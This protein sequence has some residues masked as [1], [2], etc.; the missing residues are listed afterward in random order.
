MLMNMGKYKVGGITTAAGIT[1]VGQKA[2]VTIRE[3][4]GAFL[5][6]KYYNPGANKG[7][8]IP[9]FRGILKLLNVFKMAFGTTI[10]KISLAFVGLSVLSMILSFIIGEPVPKGNDVITMFDIMFMAINVI[11]IAGILTYVMYIRNLHGLE[12]KI[13]STYNNKLSLTVENVKKQ[14]K[15]TPRCGGTLLGIAIIIE[16]VWVGVFKLPSAFV[17]LLFPTIGYEAFLH[18]AGDKWYNKAIYFPGLLIQKITTGNKVSDDTIKKYLCG[19]KA[20]VAQ[21][22]PTYSSKTNK[23]S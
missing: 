5:V 6:K 23:S 12:H 4:D 2:K 1:F 16:V 10:G 14:P 15:E 18:A 22:D 17:W 7:G 8:K 9:M 11:M 3:K 20:F 21:E 13:I 19:F